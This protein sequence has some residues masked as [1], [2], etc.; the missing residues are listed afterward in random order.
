[1]EVLIIK[2]RKKTPNPNIF[3]PSCCWIL[4][5]GIIALYLIMNLVVCILF[6]LGSV[7]FVSWAGAKSKQTQSL[8]QK[9]KKIKETFE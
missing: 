8:A 3:A 2:F 5:S 9:K 6:N 1:M 4:I 7:L